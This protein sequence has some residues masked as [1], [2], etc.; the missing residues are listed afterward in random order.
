M[1]KSEF[2]QECNNLVWLNSLGIIEYD[3]KIKSWF[4]PEDI[5][6]LLSSVADAVYEEEVDDEI[7]VEI[8]DWDLVDK[9]WSPRLD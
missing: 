2:M 3:N 1:N 9:W 6:S 4:D 8:I 7:I 5:D